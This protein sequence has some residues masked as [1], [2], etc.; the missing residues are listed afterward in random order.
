MKVRLPRRVLSAARVTMLVLLASVVAVNVYL[1]TEYLPRLL[2][3]LRTGLE[4]EYALAW[5]LWPG[6]VHVRGLTLKGE[7]PHF[8]W[9]LEA[10]FASVD[11][12]LSSLSS[13]RLSLERLS[14]AGTRA[15]LRSKQHD[16]ATALPLS[17]DWQV[18]IEDLRID[19][20]RDLRVDT[21]RFVGR[22]DARGSFFVEPGRIVRLGPTR[23][24]V[25]KGT[26][27]LDGRS[28]LDV[29]AAQFHGAL[30]PVD[31]H[32]AEGLALFATLG[33]DAELQGVVKDI[34]VL[35]RL[36]GLPSPLA[37]E[38]GQGPVKTKVWVK[39]GRVQPGSELDW[40]AQQV[41]G[42]LDGFE[43]AGGLSLRVW[44]DALDEV[45]RTRARATLTGFSLGRDGSLPL[46]L[47]HSAQLEIDAPGLDASRAHLFADELAQAWTSWPGRLVLEKPSSAG[48]LPALQWGASFE[49][50]QT[51]VDLSRI[52]EHRLVFRGAKANGAK[53]RLRPRGAGQSPAQLKLLPPLDP[54]PPPPLDLPANL[55]S[56]EVAEATVEELQEVWLEAYRFEGQARAQGGFRYES[57]GR[58]HTGPIRLSVT[59]GTLRIARWKAAEQLRGELELSL[60]DTDLQA[61]RGYGF[62]RKLS[63]RAELSA[64]LAE[65]DFLRHF[66]TLPIPAQLGG[67][68]GPA[69]LRVSLRDGVVQSG[70]EV[71]WSSPGAQAST[72]GYIVQG[73]LHLEAVWTEGPSEPR[74]RLEARI[75]PYRVTKLGG[76]RPLVRGE[77]LTLRMDAPS[78]DLARPSFQPHT[79]VQV[80]DGKVPDL[81]VINHYLPKELPLKM[82]HGSGSF[83]GRLAWSHTGAAHASLEVGGKGAELIYDKTRLKGNW[84][85]KAELANVNLL[86]AE[87][88]LTQATLLFHDMEI[89]EGARSREGWFGRVDVTG[90][91]V[92]PGQPVSLEADIETTLRDGGPLVSFFSSQTELLPGWLRGQI[93]LQALRATAR[94]RVGPGL[95]EVNELNARGQGMEI[96]GRMR[97]Q[98]TRQ[99]GDMLVST[100]AQQVGIAIRGPRFELKLVGPARWYREQLKDPQW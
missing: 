33:A 72:H 64:Q 69:S 90:G 60:A 15:R 88:D 13:D 97:R 62:F 6:T 89:R 56:L 75:S 77:R 20:L 12:R 25:G 91:K 54:P 95:L 55:C 58:L 44:V 98:G 50:I 47:A 23:V 28:A 53:I 22:M 43:F 21:W 27:E 14:L 4:V 31:L 26:F 83:S 1:N 41:K 51:Q 81:R 11:A 16:P 59:E 9:E 39:D 10:D 71:R 37:L 18:V 67:G 93:T 5:T 74:M 68:Q 86:T 92:R 78:F 45:I 73:P 38:D 29:V 96:R 35:S 70:S 76:E 32:E 100:R 36:P 66:P 63:A 24:Q 61:A 84:S 19:G 2:G 34:G 30:G 65:V 79:A 3:K 85:C 49:R 94:V 57:D 40:S 99:W 8:H 80:V 48:A 52:A 17:D 42:R 7:E 87:A 82:D 46:A